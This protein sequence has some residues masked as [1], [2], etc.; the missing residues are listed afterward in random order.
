MRISLLWIDRCWNCKKRV[1]VIKTW[2]FKGFH[3]NEVDTTY[4]HHDAGT[5]CIIIE[6]PKPVHIP[7]PESHPI[8]NVNP[9]FFKPRSAYEKRMWK[10][11][12][13]LPRNIKDEDED[14]R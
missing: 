4:L 12:K 10:N 9:K 1:L 5:D 14:E 7:H 6:R 8:P 2:G 13:R 3:I 11:N